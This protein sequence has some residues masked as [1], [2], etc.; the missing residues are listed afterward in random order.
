M[1]VELLHTEG[2]S[3]TDNFFALGGHSL[4]VIQLATRIRESFGVEVPIQRIFEA[5]TL[6]DLALSVT[7]AQLEMADQDELARL[8]D[9]TEAE[10]LE[11]E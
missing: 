11:E 7:T 5:L 9:E 3:V 1:W 8:L 10:S 2:V 4:L 6:S